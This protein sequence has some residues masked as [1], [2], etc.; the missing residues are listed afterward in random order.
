MEKKTI[1]TCLSTEF[2]VCSLT[3]RQAKLLP[4]PMLSQYRPTPPYAGIYS[5][6]AYTHLLVVGGYDQ[7]SQYRP[8]PSHAGIYGMV[9]YTNYGEGS[10]REHA[11]Q[12]KPA[13]PHAG[14]YSMVTYW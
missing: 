1:G 14:I 12:Y 6:V 13:P 7:K 10:S 11:S 5:M 2:K 9:T 8:A 3:Q 4:N